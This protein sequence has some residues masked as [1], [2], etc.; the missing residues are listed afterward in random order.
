MIE[1]KKR[2]EHDLSALSTSSP[3]FPS[4]TAS[5]VLPAKIFRGASCSLFDPI[6]APG[7]VDLQ[8][9]GIGSTTAV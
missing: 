5:A 7:L 2:H 4:S 3:Q 1:K 6:S 9:A 8:S